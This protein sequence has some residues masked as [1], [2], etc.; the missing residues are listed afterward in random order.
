MAKEDSEMH[1]KNMTIATLARALEVYPTYTSASSTVI[2]YKVL[3][4]DKNVTAPIAY[5]LAKLPANKT[6]I[7]ADELV[8]VFPKDLLRKC[9]KKVTALQTASENLSE[10][11]VVVEIPGLGVF[12][13]STLATMK[14]YH[15]SIQ[16]A[17]LVDRVIRW[18]Q[19]INFDIPMPPA[20]KTQ[21]DPDRKAKVERSQL[22]APE[23][24]AKGCLGDTTMVHLLEKLFGTKSSIVVGS[25]YLIAVESP[26]KVTLDSDRLA[27]LL[28][29]LSFEKVI[30]AV[31]AHGNHWCA[32]M[33]DVS[34]R[35]LYTYD[36]MESSY[37]IGLRTAV[38]NLSLMVPGRDK[39][40]IRIQTYEP[41][42]GI[43]TD[44]YNSDI[45]VLLAFEVFAGADT[46]GCLDK[47]SI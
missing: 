6:I 35:I 23:I 46:P 1:S 14:R 11:E 9:T 45:Y 2:K 36:P 33:L 8:R 21:E 5:K 4:V 20:F 7:D 34:A 47:K 22:L 19:T 12:K 15:I 3:M 24:A 40:R 30:I 26:T 13:T 27:D 25:S 42:L 18:C 28:L 32:I 43:Q 44:S 17:H 10:P 29:G 37:R 41:Q 16:T 38:H 31:N 39:H